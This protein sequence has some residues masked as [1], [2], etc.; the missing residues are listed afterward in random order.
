MSIDQLDVDAPIFIAWFQCLVSA[1][2]CF[3]LSHLSKTFPQ[4]IQ[5]P[6]GNPFNAITVKNVSY[7]SYTDEVLIYK[8]KK[9]KLRCHIVIWYIDWT[10]S[11]VYE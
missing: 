6:E 10:S 5:F 1:I 7:L 3:I 11:F 8:K 9:I 2:I 4:V